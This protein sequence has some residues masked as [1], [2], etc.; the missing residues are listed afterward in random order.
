M[1]VI[2]EGLD[3]SFKTTFCEKLTSKLLEAGIS[4]E[5]GRQPGGTEYAEELRKII[6]SESI[7]VKER[8]TLY[9]ETMMFLAARSQIYEMKILPAIAEGKV[10]V[11]D[12]CNLSTIAYQSFKGINEDY[13]TQLIRMAPW[14][15]LADIMFVIQIPSDLAEQRIKSR[16]EPSDYLEKRLSHCELVYKN[17]DHS[18]LSKKTIIINGLDEDGNEVTSDD[19]AEMAFHKLIETLG[20][21][22]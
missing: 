7:S 3:G 14:F 9:S 16:N 22:K 11:S 8:L 18:K 19:M 17:Y 12:R 2:C 1:L 10:F 4:A 15:T 5:M 6:K 21:N 13:L 20:E